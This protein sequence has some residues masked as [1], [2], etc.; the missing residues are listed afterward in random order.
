TLTPDER[1]ALEEI[2]EQTGVPLEQPALELVGPETG[3]P[4]QTVE[5]GG[6]IITYPD[7][8][9]TLEE[10][11]MGIAILAAAALF[12]LL[13]VGFVVWRLMRRGKAASAA[14]AEPG[15]RA[16]EPTMP[17]AF[18][19]DINRYTDDPAVQL[20]E[21]P[22]MV[23]RVAGTDTQHLD[24]LVVNKGTVGRRHAIIK[25]KDYS[26]WIVD[27][28]SVNG[29][30]VNGERISGE[31]QLKHG[32][33]VRF[34][35]YEFEF[36]QPEMDDGFHTVFADPNQAEATL[37]A[38]ASTLVGSSAMDLQPGGQEDFDVGGETPAADD[39]DALFDIGGGGGDST[40][41][42]ESPVANFDDADV[43]DITGESAMR[44]VQEADD[45]R[46]DVTDQGETAV[47]DSPL[48][49]E[50]PS[51]LMDDFEDDDEDLGV[52]INLD[53]VDEGV[54]PE[55]DY[56]GQ[57]QSD[58]DFDAEASAFFEDITV[59]PTPDDEGGPAPDADDDIFGIGGEDD[60]TDQSALDAKLEQ[61]TAIMDGTA[62]G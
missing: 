29:T 38:D 45:A 9:P 44:D 31:Q 23:G 56:G 41:E 57:Q 58:E 48:A 32:D 11:R 3:V 40:E 35:K 19:N 49:S 5:P 1:Q 53:V 4:T 51:G 28:G 37:V 21:K 26:F 59:G 13:L 20:G 55:P 10:E 47:F 24:Y 39:G 33:M 8:Q 61:A 46:G 18:I 27:Q 62:I 34:H 17:E 25:Y 43:F 22:M 50:A 15:G 14:V 52:E 6:A 16:E 12:L 42:G 54:A 30:F 7:E 36:S 60:S 2:S